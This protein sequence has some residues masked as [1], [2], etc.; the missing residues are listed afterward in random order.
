MRLLYKILGGSSLALVLAAGVFEVRQERR[1]ARLRTF[2]KEVHAGMPMSE[3][4][5]LEDVYGIDE[6]YLVKFNPDNFQRQI[7]NRNLGFRSH[8]FD[9]DFACVISHNG[10]VITSAELVPERGVAA[11][12]RIRRA[13]LGWGRVRGGG[14][15][16][17]GHNPIELFTRF[18]R[19]C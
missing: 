5:G 2:C 15:G 19:C 18:V 12:D 8:L 10:V 9:P 17:E 16:V 11:P 6:T 13:P 1:D 7:E 4:L 3:F 14:Q